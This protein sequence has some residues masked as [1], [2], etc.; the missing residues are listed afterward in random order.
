M[1]LTYRL[2][3]PLNE[4]LKRNTF[5]WFASEST[6]NIITGR[7]LLSQKFQKVFQINA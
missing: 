5:A 1:V 7:N 3:I 4:I 2:H 6:E